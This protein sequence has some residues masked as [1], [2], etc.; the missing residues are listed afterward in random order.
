M[1][2]VS[3]SKLY[4]DSESRV[5]CVENTVQIEE[6]ETIVLYGRLENVFTRDWVSEML[7]GR[8]QSPPTEISFNQ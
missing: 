4:V 7:R 1:A 2:G 5:K 6:M 8:S 3:S